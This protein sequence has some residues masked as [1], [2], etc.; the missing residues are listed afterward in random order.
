VS[1][2]DIAG[3]E[4][5]AGPACNALRRLILDPE[6]ETLEFLASGARDAYEHE[7]RQYRTLLA[8]AL[9]WQDIDETRWADELSATHFKALMG[10]AHD[11]LRTAGAY[12][13]LVHLLDE[14]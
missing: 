3:T 13:S 12:L 9:F 1:I 11:A 5:Q 2:H 14:S 7:M 6:N 8:N 4:E 10:F